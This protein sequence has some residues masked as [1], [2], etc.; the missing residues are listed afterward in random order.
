LDELMQEAGLERISIACQ[1]SRS[2]LLVTPTLLARWFRPAG[3][4]ARPNYA[5]QLR[6]CLG[7]ED[8]DRVQRIFEG[9]LLNK[10][11]VW[12]SVVAHL[13]AVKP[14]DGERG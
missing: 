12:R 6:L 14:G 11:V 4:D 10:S 2:E 13:S 9:S 8:I 5:Q 7:P 1:E 3:D